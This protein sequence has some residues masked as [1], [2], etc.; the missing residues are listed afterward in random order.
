MYFS[1]KYFFSRWYQNFVKVSTKENSSWGKK[2]KGCIG[3][4]CNLLK[5]VV[6]HLIENCFF[7]VGNIML[8]QNKGTTMGSAP[9]FFI[10]FL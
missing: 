3:F 2:V 4:T 6:K 9:E 8:K 1:N 7:T 5:V 10:M